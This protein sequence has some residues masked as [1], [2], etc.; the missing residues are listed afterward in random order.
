MCVSFGFLNV[1][2][3]FKNS[4]IVLLRRVDDGFVKLEF[5]RRGGGFW[6]ICVRIFE[7]DKVVG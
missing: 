7:N 3:E 6:C 2:L 1:V 5:G 4:G